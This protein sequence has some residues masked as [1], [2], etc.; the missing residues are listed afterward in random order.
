MTVQTEHGGKDHSRAAETAL[1][2]EF[3][4]HLNLP[5]LEP[6]SHVLKEKAGQSYKFPSP[7]LG[8]GNVTDN[9]PSL[10]SKLWVSEET[11]VHKN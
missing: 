2:V 8:D 10:L 3:T 1:S 9:Q 7:A 5:L 4:L 11:N 6:R